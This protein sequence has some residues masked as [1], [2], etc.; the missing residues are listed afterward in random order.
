MSP[1][2]HGA[3][4]ARDARGFT[5]V[6]LSVVVA[7]VGVLAAFV[8]PNFYVFA[9]R[10][11][12]TEAKNSLRAI[13]VAEE[14]YRTERDHY[15]AGDETVLREIGVSLPAKKRYAYTVL[16]LVPGVEAFEAHADSID[17]SIPE[18]HWSIN[19]RSELVWIAPTPDCR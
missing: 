12:T 15:L 8:I 1:R 5:L 9:C 16:D 18:D 19:N 11:K 13:L 6:E 14:T 10:A 4:D 2:N 3:H 17:P 7:I